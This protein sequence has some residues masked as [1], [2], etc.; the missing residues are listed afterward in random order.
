MARPYADGLAAQCFDT[1]GNEPKRFFPAG[2]AKI[3]AT[4]VPHERVQQTFRIAYD[5]MGSLPANTQKTL[6]IGVL[7]IPANL[8]QFVA[9]NDREH[10]AQG[11]VAVHWAHRA[12]IVR[13]VRCC[14]VVMVGYAQ[15][16]S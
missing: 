7:F 14:S 6:A 10:P 8:H 2:V 9:V 15:A 11:G 13:T 12:H 3:I 5:L 1:I 16:S 4:P